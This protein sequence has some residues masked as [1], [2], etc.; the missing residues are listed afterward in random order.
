VCLVHASQEEIDNSILS[1]TIQIIETFVQEANWPERV[2]NMWKHVKK[3]VFQTG[4]HT[5]ESSN[6]STQKTDLDNIK[7]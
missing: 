6:S 5:N 4:T 3:A 2:I 1:N 7:A